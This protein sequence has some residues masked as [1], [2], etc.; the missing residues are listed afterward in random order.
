M[1]YPN[2]NMNVVHIPRC[3]GNSFKIYLMSLYGLTL[4]ETIHK[5]R[6]VDEGVWEDLNDNPHL[7]D[8]KIIIEG[9]L[10]KFAYSYS[11]DSQKYADKIL[12]D[13]ESVANTDYKENIYRWPGVDFDL[14]FGHFGIDKWKHLNKRNIVWLRDPLERALS[15]WRFHI[16]AQRYFYFSDADYDSPDEIDG[17]G[18]MIFKE[19]MDVNDVI[20]SDAMVDV[21]SQYAGD[22]LSVFDF[23]GKVENFDNDLIRFQDMFGLDRTHIDKTNKFNSLSGLIDSHCNLCDERTNILKQSVDKERF[24]KTHKR[25]YELYNSLN[26]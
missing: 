9:E 5:G 14:I 19:K 10:G 24:Y 25:D 1:D 23:V 22:D 6:D 15:E 26:R 13:N 20:N 18:R 21:L 16:L 4:T 2:L 7:V 17:I 11:W 12:F 3:A 8:A